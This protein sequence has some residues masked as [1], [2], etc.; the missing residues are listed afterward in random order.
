MELW[1]W[2]GAGAVVAVAAAIG[3]ARWLYAVVTVYGSSLEP[4]HCH[5]DR[6]LARRCGVRRI[7]RGQLVVFAEPGLGRRHP[8]RW[9]GAGRNVWVIKRVAATAGDTVPDALRPAVGDVS[10]VPRQAIVV[11]GNSPDSRDSRHWGFIKA[12]QILGVAARR[13]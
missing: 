7:R 11:L 13:I 1:W 4:E 8:A 9:T 10:I 3:L 5:G 6:L 12:S 2:F